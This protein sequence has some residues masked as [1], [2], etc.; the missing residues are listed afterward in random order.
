MALTMHWTRDASVDELL[1]LFEQLNKEI[2]I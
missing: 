2:P 1:S